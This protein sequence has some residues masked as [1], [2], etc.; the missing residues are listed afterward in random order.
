M[1][2]I[3]N[4]GKS[5]QW[6][7]I[8]GMDEVP[9]SLASKTLDEIRIAVERWDN[10]RVIMTSRPL[11]IFNEIP[12]KKV[13]QSLSEYKILDVVNFIAGSGVDFFGYHAFRAM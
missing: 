12:E 2:T 9:L 3:E 7:I 11:S 8:D 4:E 13:I 10:L 5:E 1:K 6:I